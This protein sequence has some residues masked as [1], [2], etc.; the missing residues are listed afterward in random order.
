M[1]SKAHL[2]P[3]QLNIKGVTT[4]PTGQIPIFIYGNK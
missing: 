1:V 2:V 4:V 3:V